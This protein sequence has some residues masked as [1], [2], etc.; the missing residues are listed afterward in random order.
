MNHQSPMT[1]DFA[2]LR[3][4]FNRLRLELGLP[5]QRESELERERQSA[6]KVIKAQGYEMEKD[7]HGYTISGKGFYKRVRDLAY[8]RGYF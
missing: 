1:R 4:M 6:L 5:T 8:F 2:E 7:E 3:K